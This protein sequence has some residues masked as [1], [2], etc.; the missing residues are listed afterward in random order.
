[1]LDRDKFSINALALILNGSIL[2]RGAC[3]RSI[4]VWERE[5]SV[6]NMT[7][8]GTLRGHKCKILCL[9]NVAE[10]VSSGSADNTIK[11]AQNNFFQIFVVTAIW[12]TQL[13][14]LQWIMPR[15]KCSQSSP[16]PRSHSHMADPK[17][18]WRVHFPT[19]LRCYECT[20][21]LE[22]ACISLQGNR[23]H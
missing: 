1:M 16:N 12:N 3:D 14:W 13:L 5:G 6:R 7:V 4:I 11:Q 15:K 22:S 19:D 20:S 21:G 2:Y 17:L 10:F 9:A 8:S 23:S 18:H